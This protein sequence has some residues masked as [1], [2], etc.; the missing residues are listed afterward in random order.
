[1]MIKNNKN[2]PQNSKK[3]LIDQQKE[4]LKKKLIHS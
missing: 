4:A 2:L 3:S 1:M